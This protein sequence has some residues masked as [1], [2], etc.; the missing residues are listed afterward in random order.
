MRVK[1]SDVWLGAVQWMTP[2]DTIIQR[3]LSA[4]DSP[5]KVH[6]KDDALYM[7]PCP[8]IQ[9]SACRHMR[10]TSSLQQLQED[11]TTVRLPS[12]VLWWG[13]PPQAVNHLHVK[14]VSLP[15]VAYWRSTVG[16]RRLHDS[17]SALRGSTIP[18]R[19]LRDGCKY[20]LIRII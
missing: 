11:C 6:T 20:S 5:R 16:G 18:G 12:L 15:M 10:N 1:C 17:R 13:E 7:S 8:W 19:H 3:A 14:S 2:A 9:L 4:A